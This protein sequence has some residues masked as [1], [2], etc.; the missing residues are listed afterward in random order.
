[1][2]Y[3]VRVHTMKGVEK[4]RYICTYSTYMQPGCEVYTIENIT[5]SE[6][7]CLVEEDCNIVI[8]HLNVY[9]NK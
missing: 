3:G 1:M 5:E 8:Q 6:V 2:R 9:W 7:F 4:R